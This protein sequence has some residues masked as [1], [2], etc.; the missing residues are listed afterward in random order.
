MAVRDVGELIRRRL[1]AI[2]ETVPNLGEKP[3]GS[4]PSVWRN[5]AN[6]PPDECPAIFLLDRNEGKDTQGK[7]HA[8]HR[9]VPAIM[10]L[11]PEIWVQ[12]KQTDTDENE[13]VGEA[14]AEFRV[15]ILAAIFAD[16]ELA[17]LQGENGVI[18]YRGFETDM[19][20]GSSIGA[21]GAQMKLD[22]T[23]SY[24]FDPGD[25]IA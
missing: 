1:I 5:R 22:L 6:L 7:G 16:D 14:L 18:E 25:L 13:G 17:A 11:E 2:F 9:M 20:S 15:N 19:Q 12:L 10:R 21:E 4:G 24:F 3:D 23:F 8:G